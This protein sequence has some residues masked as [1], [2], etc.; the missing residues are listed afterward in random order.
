MGWGES[1][2]L[3]DGQVGS[4]VGTLSPWDTLHHLGPLQ[5]LHQLEGA[6]HRESGFLYVLTCRARARRNLCAL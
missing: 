4:Q 1:S 3:M 2:A 6:G 5:R